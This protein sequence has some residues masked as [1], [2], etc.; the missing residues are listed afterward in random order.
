M[1]SHLVP[2][3]RV[4]ACHIFHG[5]TTLLSPDLYNEDEDGPMENQEDSRS[6]GADMRSA[7]GERTR[8]STLDDMHE[9]DTPDGS[10]VDMTEPDSTRPHAI[11]YPF[12]PAWI[13]EEALIL[14]G[15]IQKNA[16]AEKTAD[17]SKVLLAGHGLGG[18]VVK[19]VMLTFSN[20]VLEFT[21]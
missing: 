8:M 6:E 21:S 3:A 9:R 2:E 20:A 12:S 10:D 18:I 19:K 7:A 11:K 15:K 5:G 4:V 14:L 17:R 13:E 1:I 16:L